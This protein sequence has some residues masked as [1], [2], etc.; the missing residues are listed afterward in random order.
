VLAGVEQIY[1]L[2][3]ALRCAFKN[4]SMSFSYFLISLEPLVQGGGGSPGG[5]APLFEAMAQRV[6]R[7]PAVMKPRKQW[8][9]HPFGTRKRWWEA[10]SC[11][12]RGLEQVRTECRLTGL[13]YTR[14]RVLNLG[15]MPRL[16]AA[17]G[18]D[19]LGPQCPE[20]LSS[21]AR[22][23]LGLMFTPWLSYGSLRYSQ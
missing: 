10:G 12:M 5:D 20:R 6:R 19:G 21:S 3:C 8:V 14:R 7:W 17:L 13:A 15:E 4:F 16:L 23:A 18:G 1:A 9:E 22:D 11:L 2:R